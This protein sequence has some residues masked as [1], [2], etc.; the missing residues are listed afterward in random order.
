M[1]LW[2]FALA[3]AGVGIV[4]GLVWGLDAAMLY[5]SFAVIVMLFAAYSS[6]AGRLTLKS[7]LWGAARI[8]AGVVGFAWKGFWVGF[9]FV[10]GV[11]VLQSVA[12]AAEDVYV[13]RSV[14]SDDPG[15]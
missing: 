13:R 11:V 8:A 4:V 3:L 14:S 1:R 7:V 5:F 12:K 10:L 6:E 2:H 9:G 15:P